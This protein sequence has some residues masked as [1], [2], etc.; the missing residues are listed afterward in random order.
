M[1]DVTR[2]T[3]EKT[4]IGQLPLG[5]DVNLERA[6]RAGDRMGGHIVTGH[7]DGVAS[8]VSAQADGD[9]THVV[10]SA[11]AELMRYIAPKGSVTLDGVSLTVNLVRAQHFEIMLIPHTLAVTTLK[12][13]RANTQ[14]NLEVDLMAR[15]AI[16]YLEA[17]LGREEPARPSARPLAELLSEMSRS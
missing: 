13:L 1:V 14:L 4:T 3:A 8:V 5:S 2:E 7:V 9:A 11:P 15:Y 17:T 16:R 12:R 6:L 10:L